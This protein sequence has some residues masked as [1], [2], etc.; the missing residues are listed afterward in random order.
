M[1]KSVIVIASVLKPVNDVRM[2]KKFAKS[3]AA[4]PDYEIHLVG[5][6]ARVEEA[7]KSNL[8][9]HPIF[10]FSRLSYRRLFASL[11]LLKLLY[12]LKPGILIVTTHEL[13]PAACIYKL[14]FGSRLIYDVQENYYRNILYT[15]AFPP[16]IR[17]LL[18]FGVRA[19]EWLSRPFV[20]HYIL[21]EKCYAT[22]FGFAKGK[23]VILPNKYTG[24]LFSRSQKKNDSSVK[25]ICLLYS[26]TIAENYGIYEAISL[27]SAL[28]QIDDRIKL[29]IA[30]FASQKNT[31]SQVQKSIAGKD[32]IELIGGDSIVPHDRIE[33]EIHKADFGLICYRPNKSTEN[34]IPTKLYEYLA[35]QLPILLFPNSLWESICDE[36]GAA[37]KV[38]LSSISP[39]QLLSEMSAR[40][41][42]RKTPGE[43][44]RWNSE[45][46]RLI[47]LI[48]KS[49][50]TYF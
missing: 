45:A 29:T 27:A 12:K 30:G 13:V 16:G 39:A 42:Y 15:S 25:E 40:S 36:Y 46:I 9:F 10:R 50:N 22:E 6:S 7:A 19:F 2:Y 34:C 3:L 4:E 33:E 35:N 32:F 38:D 41:F 20:D 14:L 44:V 28:Y 17:H 48:K 43:E 37:I 18:A 1:N 5:T 26:G 11:Q 21:A 47:E 49:Q 24:Q 23:F 31:L 8:F